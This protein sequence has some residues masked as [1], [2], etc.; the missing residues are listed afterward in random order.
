MLGRK[1]GIWCDHE[2]GAGGDALDLVRH[3]RGCSMSEAIEWAAAWLGMVPGA[4]LPR[5]A[6]PK[7]APPAPE[8]TDN[9]D[10]DLC[11]R[12]ARESVP[13]AGTIG[14]TYLR[15][16]GCEPPRGRVLRFHPSCPRG[17]ERL[18][19]MLALLTDPVTNR[20]VGLH[21]T[22]LRPDGIG[23][24]EHGKAKMMLGNAGLIRLAPDD[25]ITIGLGI[26]EGIET[27]LA[28]MQRAGWAA[29]WA[30]GSAGAI[31]KFPVL[32]GIECLTV[33]PDRDDEGAGAKAAETCT[34]R[35]SAAGREAEVIWPPGGADWNDAL[36]GI[37]A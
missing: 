15:F 31:A 1:R 6:R 37:A 25:E 9:R 4:P 22:F 29:I 30:A 34:E 5:T 10:L 23:K 11:L 36:Q 17:Q 3:L 7:A 32:A 14:E 2:A 27:G 16:R 33:F 18:P 19:A 20:F 8:P 13:L 12:L 28:L 24:I 35:W 21:R 26:C